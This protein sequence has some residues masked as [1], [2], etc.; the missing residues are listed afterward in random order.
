M[1][2]W[3]DDHY[4]KVSGPLATAFV[5][6]HCSHTERVRKGMQGVG[7]GYGLR[8]VGKAHGR[9]VTHVKEAHSDEKAVA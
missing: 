2:S 3:T 4:D 9:M 1:K 7:R 6:K 5:C 8:E